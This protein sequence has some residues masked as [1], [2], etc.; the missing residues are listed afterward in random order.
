MP[1]GGGCA[2]R[3]LCNSTTILKNPLVGRSKRPWWLHLKDPG[4]CARKTRVVSFKRPGWFTS[5]HPGSCAPTTMVFHDQPPWSFTRLHPHP[6]HRASSCWRVAL[7][8]YARSEEITTFAQATQIVSSIANIRQ[9]SRRNN[10]QGLFRSRPSRTTS[11]TAAAKQNV[12]P[13]QAECLPPPEC[14]T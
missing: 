14:E 2:G 4:G 8:E 3:G 7:V 1:G 12:N 6:V 10:T 5:N 9:D 11:P 13:Q